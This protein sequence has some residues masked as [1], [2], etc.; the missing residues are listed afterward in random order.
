MKRSKHQDVEIQVTPMLDMAFQLLTFFI[1]TYRPAPTEGQFSM[2][3]LPAAPAIDMA[4]EA[5]AAEQQAQ[6]ADLPAALRTLTTTI[7]ARPDGSIAR[8]VIGES[9]FQTLDQL[10]DRLKEIMAD[11]DLLFDQAVIQADPDLSWAEL[12]KVVDVFAGP[13]V[14]L[15]KLSFTELNP[16]GGAL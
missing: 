11:R 2:N 4:A 12:I 3:L 7:H 16:A 1:L 13:G 10:R 5:P 6:S 15:T 14:N 9:E 8:I